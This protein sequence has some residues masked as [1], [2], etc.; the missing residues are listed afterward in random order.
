M[1]GRPDVIVTRAIGELD[2]FE[3]ILEEL[4]LRFARPWTRQLK[5]VEGANFHREF[6]IPMLRL[7]S[8]ILLSCRSRLCFAA[9]KLH[10][11]AF[12]AH[13][14]IEAIPLQFCA[15]KRFLIFAVESAACSHEMR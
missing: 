6:T 5:F 8:R 11:R 14:S 1:L 15:G 12:A 10:Y 3:R 9:S 2:L 4:M 13:C 7:C